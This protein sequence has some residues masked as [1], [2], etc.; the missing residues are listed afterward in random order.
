[1]T[2]PRVFEAEALRDGRLADAARKNFQRHLD[3]CAVCAGQAA[4]LKRLADQVKA[5]AGDQQSDDL[6][7]WRE[8]TRLL[9]AFDHALLSPKRLARARLLLWPLAAAAVISAVVALWRARPAREPS[10]EALATIQADGGT[11]WFRHPAAGGREEIGLQHGTL[12][13]HV[14]RAAGERAVRVLL[15]DGELEDL[16]TTFTVSADGAHTT[17]VTVEEGTVVLRLRGRASLDLRAGDVWPSASPAPTTAPPPVEVP[18]DVHRQPPPRAAR[19][20]RALH[21]PAATVADDPLV[22]FRTAAAALRAGDNPEAA[23][24]FARFLAEHPAHPMAEDAAYLRVIALQRMGAG[25]DMKRA[26]Q[27]YLQRFPT[28]FRRDE[29][30]RLTR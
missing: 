17:R 12:W 19:P 16:G 18:G 7:V 27:V 28:G 11:A 2:C 22:A 1:M 13:I 8:R 29:V 30:S 26:A 5:G 14:D 23:A 4:A 10:R 25:A 9:A 6:H 15:P 3:T 21:Q 20:L 24:A